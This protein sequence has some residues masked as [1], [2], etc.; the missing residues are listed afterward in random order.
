[1]KMNACPENLINFLYKW[2]NIYLVI[3]TYLNK[4]KMSFFFKYISL[5]K[6]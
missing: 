6:I 3:A 1:M 2:T 5:Q 4:R